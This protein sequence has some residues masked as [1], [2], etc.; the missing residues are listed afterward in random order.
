MSMANQVETVLT[1]EL[2]PFLR[3]ENYVTVATVDHESGGPNVNAIS[4]V[5]A[6]DNSHIRFAV[7]NRSKMLVNLQKQ[8]RIT[9]T[10][11]GAGSTYAISGNAR[12]ITEKIDNIPLKLALVEIKIR[13]V[14]DVMFYGSKITTEPKYEKTYDEEA[15][16]KLDSQVMSALKN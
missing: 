3:E 14:R 10:M 13:E 4:W 8:P 12:V 9:I 2:L 1:E 6:Q 15:A 11:L 16:Q 5:Y 7:D